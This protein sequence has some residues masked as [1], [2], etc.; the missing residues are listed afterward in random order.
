MD[1]EQG[2]Q[3]QIRKAGAGWTKMGR[4]LGGEKTRHRTSK[5]K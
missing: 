4:A 5:K 1:A 3:K 2:R